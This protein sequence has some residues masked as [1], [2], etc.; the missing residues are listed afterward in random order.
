MFLNYEREQL[1][2]HIFVF[3]SLSVVSSTVAQVLTGLGGRLT[4]VSKLVAES[5]AALAGLADL[6]DG[7]CPLLGL[8]MNCMGLVTGL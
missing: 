3:D 8:V 2:F 7:L 5:V 4:D 1:T 6:F